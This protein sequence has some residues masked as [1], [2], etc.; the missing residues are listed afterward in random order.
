M[1]ERK[2]KEQAQLEAYL[3]AKRAYEKKMDDIDWNYEEYVPILEDY[4]AGRLK[5]DISQP[6]FALEMAKDDTKDN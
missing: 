4:K 3:R 2:P 5:I 1:A 6:L